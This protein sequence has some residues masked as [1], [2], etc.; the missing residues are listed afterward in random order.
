[1]IDV[2]ALRAL[3]VECVTEAIRKEKALLADD[4][5]LTT[6]EA[7]NEARVD[8]GTIRSWVTAGHLQ[9]RTTG[10]G[11]HLRISRAELRG[12]LASEKARKT[13]E[14]VTPQQAARLAMARGGRR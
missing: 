8:V 9:R 10:T 13:G 3:I 14:G 5:L 7:A 6:A 1:M 12:Y 2:A 11:G 4:A